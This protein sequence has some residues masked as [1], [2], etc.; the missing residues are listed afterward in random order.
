MTR[1]GLLAFVALAASC[2][3][4]PVR[5]DRIANAVEWGVAAC[6]RHFLEGV[7]LG[8]ALAGLADGRAYALDTRNVEYWHWDA[9]PFRLDG[10]SVYVGVSKDDED[11]RDCRVIAVGAGSPDLRDAVVEKRLAG[12]DR[13]WTDAT[14]NAR[15]L[16]AACTVDRVPEGKSVLL[17]A[18]VNA[19]WRVDTASMPVD[20]LFEVALELRDSCEREPG[21]WM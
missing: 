1:M 16:R 3:T 19:F 21:F 8:D 14:R 12:T 18:K 17:T 11:G 7:A 4:A 15:G 5:N 9:E 20:P 10:L 2:A 6:E 13:A